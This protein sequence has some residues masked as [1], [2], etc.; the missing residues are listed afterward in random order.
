MMNCNV[1]KDLIPLYIDRCCSED[2]ISAV[3]EH[4]ASCKTCRCML[5][6]MKNPMKE[7]ASVPSAP[8]KMSRVKGW[9]ASV[10]Q[11]LLLFLSFAAVTIGVTFEAATPLGKA[12][13]CWAVALIVPATG[14]LLSLANWYFV[15]LYKSKRAFSN[16]SLL[17]TAGFIA[18]AYIWAVLHYGPAAAMLGAFAIGISLSAVLC[19]LSKL[20]SGRYAAMLGK[21]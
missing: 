2:S 4:I 1:V 3:E 9:Q 5:E 12:N 15:N 6:S 18:L 19:V 10:M 13:G 8:A 14:F 11:S 21:E 7:T 20:L 17:L 16:C